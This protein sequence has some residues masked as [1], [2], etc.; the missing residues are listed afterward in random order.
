MYQLK[1]PPPF[2]PGNELAGT[3]SA[4]GDGVTRFAV[5]DKVIATPTGG[6]FAEKCAVNENLVYPL[7]N[8]SREQVSR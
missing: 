2:V 6:A 7:P 4:V 8:L 3:I 5:G 1:T